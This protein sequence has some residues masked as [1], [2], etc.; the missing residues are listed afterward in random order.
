MFKN[1]KQN[2]K[3]IKTTVSLKIEIKE[4]SPFLWFD[5]SLYTIIKNYIST[6][7]E[8]NAGFDK[9]DGNFICWINHKL[10]GFL[11]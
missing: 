6:E 1:C 9:T 5:L 10:W 7:R 11:S 4:K 2:I 8:I 3:V